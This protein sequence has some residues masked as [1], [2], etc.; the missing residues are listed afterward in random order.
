MDTLNSSLNSN[1]K[2]IDYFR[3][4]TSYKVTVKNTFRPAVQEFVGLFDDNDS[5]R[6]LLRPLQRIRSLLGQNGSLV[7]DL[8]GVLRTHQEILRR[9]LVVENVQTQ[10]L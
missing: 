2:K 9:Q 6:G 10:K 4:C 8:L 3:Y 5:Q 7:S 1:Y